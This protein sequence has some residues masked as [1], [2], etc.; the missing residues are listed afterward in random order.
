VT[1]SDIPTET[2]RAAEITM[3]K[4]P[5]EKFNV[6]A[7]NSA[8]TPARSVGVKIKSLQNELSIS[9]IKPSGEWELVSVRLRGAIGI[10]NGL[11]R[12]E[13]TINFDE[14][15][16]GLIALSGA[17][18]KGKTTLIENCHPFPQLLTRKGKLQNHFFLRNSFREVIFRNSLTGMLAKFLIQIDGANK[19]GACKC[20]AFRKSDGAESYEPV[21]GVDGNLKPYEDIL[22]RTF[23]PLDLYLRTAFI[24]QR[25]TK[26]LPDLT[27][28]TAGEK[29][30]LF[31]ELAGINYL[32]QFADAAAD[33]AKQEAAKTHD[34][35]IKSQMLQAAISGK[36][37]AAAELKEAETALT[38]GR[39]ELE[40]VLEKGKEA[41]ADV[42][43]LQASYEEEKERQ[44][45][46]DRTSG[47]I[48][49]AQIDIGKRENDIAFY[50][51]TAQNKTVFEKAIADGEAL[52]KTIEAENV[53]KQQNLEKNAEKQREFA[54]IKADFD[55]KV[56]N[57][58]KERGGIQDQRRILEKNVIDVRHN[59]DLYERDTAEIKEDCPTCG[60]R[61]PADKL[62]EL[63]NKREQFLAKIENEKA[64]EAK[65]STEINTISQ[66]IKELDEALAFL[67]FDEPAPGDDIP[68]DDTALREATTELRQI[69]IPAA[70][71]G[72]AMARDAAVRIEGFER[73]I[74]TQ[75]EIIAEKT[76]EL[77]KL[78]AAV[79]A[80]YGDRLSA[81]LEKA[82]TLHA[83][84]TVSYT[85]IK[86]TIARNEALIEAVRRKLTDIAARE[87]ELAEIKTAVAIVKK[88]AADWEL[89]ARGFGKDGVQALELDAL[90]PGIS[91]T[92]NRILDKAFNGRYRIDIQTTRIGGAGKNTKQIE[93]FLIYVTDTEGGGEP[94]LLEDK[95]GG[96]AVWIKRAIYDA[97][98]VTRKRNTNF[99]FLTCFQD[100]TDGALDSAAKTAYCRML[101]AAHA[102]SKLRHTIIITH[103]N[104][105]KA[106]IEQK[107]DMEELA[108]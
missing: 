7:E 67:A 97:F 45:N 12:E 73:E 3:V 57:L 55:A 34:A 1:I 61:L 38:A 93:D 63:K 66:R 32:Q 21:E 87:A 52:Q 96:E 60:Q 88:D 14:Y 29:K 106:M 104:E 10:R 41:K 65:L 79:E 40:I 49:N 101:E 62:A 39:Q 98:A 4:T 25:P 83:S 42:D 23:G 33:K 36:D 19:S 107:I 13:I 31:V 54:K 56:K 51:Q 75:Q 102:E 84:L 6:W 103:S 2:V 9:S 95:S 68:F 35:E 76:A 94:V 24:T 78:D 105:V 27:D 100:E 11:N 89:I 72:L 48:A 108:Q 92:A 70:R 77:E 43:R 64:T 82:K 37:G 71:S 16:P 59:I 8:V 22:A 86:T 85:E 44:R 18:G 46:A 53:K 99:A 91:D 26:N 58:E 74:K 50:K 17:N 5:A 20:F 30:T 80:G 47:A 28:A 81:E 90:A 15:A 69:D